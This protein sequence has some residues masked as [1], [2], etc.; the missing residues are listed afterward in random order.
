MIRRCD[1]IAADSKP[2]RED[3]GEEFNKN[4]A[5]LP[6]RTTVSESV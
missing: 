2:A 6:A 1:S 4:N 5:V 3:R